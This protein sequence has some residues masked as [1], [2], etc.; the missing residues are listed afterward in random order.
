MNT[1]L[2]MAVCLFFFV[3]Y[4]YTDSCAQNKAITS[5]ENNLKTGNTEALINVLNETVEVNID[6][7]RTSLSKA[8]SKTAIKKFLSTHPVK[9]FE[10]THKGASGASGYAIG[11]YTS[12][13]GSYRVVV[14]TQGSFIAK[15]D[16]T[17]E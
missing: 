5:F 8:E 4:G 3:L 16:F 14:K 7:I 6:G 10:Y 17:K 2:K 12:G 15:I 9:Q 13:E 11:K 1:L